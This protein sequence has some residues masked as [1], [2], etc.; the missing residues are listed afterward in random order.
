M[1][2]PGKPTCSRATL[3]QGDI[4]AGRHCGRANYA[5]R[6]AACSQAACSQAALQQVISTTG[7][8]LQQ[9][10][11]AAERICRLPEQPGGLA[12]ERI[13]SK[14]NLQQGHT[15]AGRH[16]S[17]ATLRQSEFAGFRRGQKSILLGRAD[18][19]RPAADYRR[20]TEVKSRQVKSKSRL[21]VQI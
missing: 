18:V 16:C 14:T 1:S 4:A 21:S 12:A 7:R 10:D 19:L 5:S 17:R 15:A 11:I 8:H 3:Q 20:L 6:Q 13:C 9:G 2:C